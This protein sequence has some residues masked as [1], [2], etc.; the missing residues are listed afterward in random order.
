MK[1]APESRLKS[2]FVGLA[3]MTML[4]IVTSAVTTN[5]PSHSDFGDRVGKS[6]PELRLT[7][8]R[9]YL[10]KHNHLHLTMARKN[11]AVHL[12]SIPAIQDHS[13]RAT[14]FGQIRLLR[15]ATAQ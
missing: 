4:A 2:R 14:G 12:G 6:H 5:H 15:N 13:R 11:L 9:Y 8:F 7:G 3:S 1:Q 10:R